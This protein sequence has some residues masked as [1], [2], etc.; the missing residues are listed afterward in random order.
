VTLGDV[1]AEMRRLVPFVF[2]KTT[3]SCEHETLLTHGAPDATLQMANWLEANQKDEPVSLICET[4]IILPKYV[5]ARQSSHFPAKVERAATA[6]DLAKDL[7]AYYRT[8]R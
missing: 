1:A 3:I 2:T 7:K 4:Q 5:E 6:N 8:L